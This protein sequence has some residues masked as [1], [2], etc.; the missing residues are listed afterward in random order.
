MEPGQEVDVLV[1]NFNEKYTIY[2]STIANDFSD[3][4]IVF[5]EIDFLMNPVVKNKIDFNIV[6]EKLQ[7]FNNTDF[8]N[9][10]NPNELFDIF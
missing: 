3:H 7:L 2:N 5:C 6:I 8:W 9:I 4:S 10:T 1:T